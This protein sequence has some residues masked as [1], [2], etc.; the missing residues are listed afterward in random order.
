MS[1]IW[2]TSIQGNDRYLF[3]AKVHIGDGMASQSLPCRVASQWLVCAHASAGAMP[4]R[5]R[6]ALS[7]DPL[8]LHL[9]KHS[10]YTVGHN[11]HACNVIRFLRRGKSNILLNFIPRHGICIMTPNMLLEL[12]M[13]L[14]FEIYNLY[15]TQ[16]TVAG[17]IGNAKHVIKTIFT[18]T[19]LL[20][21]V[22]LPVVLCT[23]DGCCAVLHR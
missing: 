12:V 8:P 13:I 18:Y 5:L 21:P 7:V 15:I 16:R 3:L 23:A 20:A 4:E 19:V 1:V 22:V 10:A 14:K 6:T 11:A 9:A 17:N 2:G